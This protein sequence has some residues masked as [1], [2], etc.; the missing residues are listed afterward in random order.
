[1][2]FRFNFLLV[3]LNLNPHI[4]IITITYN[5]CKGLEKTVQN[6]KQ[7]NYTHKEMILVDGN[8]NDASIDFLKTIQSDDIKIISEPDKG[9]YDAMNKGIDLAEGDWCIFMNAGDV[10]SSSEILNHIPWENIKADVIYGNCIIH[11]DGGFQREMKAKNL[12]QLWKGLS[13]SHQSVFVKTHLLKE[14][15]FDLEFKYC[16]D[17]YQLFSLYRQKKSFYYFDKT[18]AKIEAGGVSDQKRYKATN[19]VYKINKKLNP[20]FKIHFY[21]IPK[22]V[23]GFIVVKLKFLLPKSLIL[24]LTAYKYK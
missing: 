16:A 3:F 20:T 10:F 6:F 18:I 15:H 24:K 4:S 17:F 1:M 8:S 5:N 14:N 22:I 2:Y 21:F 11:Y 23:W 12:N 13:F 19:E 7:L 9:I